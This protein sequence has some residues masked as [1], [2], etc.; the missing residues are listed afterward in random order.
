MALHLNATLPGLKTKLL[1]YA[2]L[3]VLSTTGRAN[4]LADSLVSLNNPFTTDLMITNIQSNIT[5]YGLF[6][7]SIVQNTDF[8]AAGKAKSI[9]PTLGLY[10][11]PPHSAFRKQD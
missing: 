5:A 10:V 2:N 7:G 9:S 8:A 4:N 6:V 11:F 1:D 3:T